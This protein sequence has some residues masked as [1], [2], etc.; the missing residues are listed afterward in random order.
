M[1]CEKSWSPW[2]FLLFLQCFTDQVPSKVREKPH[3]GS[4]SSEKTWQVKTNF[5]CC[6]SRKISSGQNSESIL[7]CQ[8]ETSYT[9]YNTCKLPKNHWFLLIKMSLMHEK[10]NCLWFHDVTPTLILDAVRTLAKIPYQISSF[11]IHGGHFNRRKSMMFGKLTSV[12]ARTGNKISLKTDTWFMLII[13]QKHHYASPKLCSLSFT[14]V[15][16]RRLIY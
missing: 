14:E 6:L 8:Q 16:F 9:T 5:N 2:F 10:C 13:Y 12:A 11:F 7:L 15:K 4:I 1:F 3:I